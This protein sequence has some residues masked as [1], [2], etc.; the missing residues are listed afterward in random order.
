LYGSNQR[1]DTSGLEQTGFWLLSYVV[2]VILSQ[3]TPTGVLPPARQKET[4]FLPAPEYSPGLFKLLRYC[5][6]HFNI[7][8]DKCDT[9]NSMG[10][11]NPLLTK[12]CVELIIS[13]WPASGMREYMRHSKSSF[14]MSIPWIQSGGMNPILTGPS[15]LYRGVLKGSRDQFSIRPP[16]CG[17][18]RLVC[19]KSHLFT[20]ESKLTRSPRYLG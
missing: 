15:E 13:I 8:K 3:S 17:S 18:L 10:R 5:S 14:L 2:A 12:S 4:H 19:C 7:N 20:R 9:S 6:S 16:G 11:R 1:F